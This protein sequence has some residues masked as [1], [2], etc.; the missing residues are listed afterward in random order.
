MVGWVALTG[1]PG[2]GKS[3]VGRIVARRLLVREVGE[4][5]LERGCGRAVPRDGVEVDLPCLSR[6]L[7]REGRR[8]PRR[9]LVGHLSH[10]FP[11]DGVV[12]L[13]C[14][15]LELE[16]RLKR[17]RSPSEERNENLLAEVTDRIL[18]EALGRHRRVWEIDTTARRPAD[19]AREVERT[20]AN[21]PPARF[22]RVDWLA[23]RGVSEQLLRWGK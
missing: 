14:H 16:R 23:D 17:R 2:T 13:R 6:S 1:T 5:A 12:V 18:I 21:G 10:L 15:P 20:V 22:G 9:I 4:L 7:R 19:V 8:G 11:V 3:S